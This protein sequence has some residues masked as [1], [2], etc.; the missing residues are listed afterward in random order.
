MLS[1]SRVLL[2]GSRPLIDAR[3]RVGHP[4]YSTADVDYYAARIIYLAYGK[5]FG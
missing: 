4:R 2:V 3:G 1:D 5:F